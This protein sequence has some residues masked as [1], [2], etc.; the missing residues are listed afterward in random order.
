MFLLDDH[1]LQLTREGK[2]SK[3]VALLRAQ[4]P[5]VME[6]KLEGGAQQ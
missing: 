3:E 6:Q 5:R 1:L 2:I 4:S